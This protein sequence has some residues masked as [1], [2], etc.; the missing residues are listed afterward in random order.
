M[1]SCCGEQEGM[2]SKMM[3]GMED[4]CKVMMES[5]SMFLELASYATLEVRGLFED[6]LDGVSSEILQFVRGKKKTTPD[7]IVEKMKILRASAIFFI[8]YLARQ[9]KLSIDE[10]RIVEASRIKVRSKE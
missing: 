10:V 2:G 1:N 6:W 5:I 4:M 8:S 9:N 3:G 7:E